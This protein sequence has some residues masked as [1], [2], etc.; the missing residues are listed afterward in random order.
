MGKK[1]RSEVSNSASSNVNGMLIQARD[2]TIHG[3]VHSGTENVKQGDVHVHNSAPVITGN[4][5]TYIAGDNAG[6]IRKTFR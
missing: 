1:N 5:T 3:D 6:G 2:V 4:G